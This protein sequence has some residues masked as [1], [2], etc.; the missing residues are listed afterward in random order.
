YHGPWLVDITAAI[1]SMAALAVLLRFWRP[2]GTV[3]AP[4]RP[5]VPGS[6]GV[7]WRAWMPWLVLSVLV[8]AWGTPQVKNFLNAIS[9]PQIQISGLHLQVMRTPPVVLKPTAETA[10]FNFN[11]LSASGSAICIAAW[12]SGFL[13]GV[14]AG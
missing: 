1:V 11:W 4:A 8:F 3:A 9:A 7:V 13:L 6:R 10:I 14:P 12:I 2:P 5:R